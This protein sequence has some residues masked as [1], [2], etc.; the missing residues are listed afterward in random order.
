MPDPDR[1]LLA[2]VRQE[3]ARLAAELQEMAALR[4]ELARLEIQADIARAK[5][6]AIVLVS[7]AIMVLTSLPI[8]AVYLAEVLDLWQG[9]PRAVWLVVFGLG[10][11]IGGTLLAWLAWRRF[12]REFT[13]LEETLEEL[14]EDLIWLREWTGRTKEED[15][16]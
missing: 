8:L 1:S 13:G 5:R 7:A 9:I 2:D 10:L 11:L 4:W 3:I 12:R 14:R 16:P 6:L 15:N